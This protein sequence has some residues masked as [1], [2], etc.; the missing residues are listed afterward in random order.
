MVRLTSGW[1]GAV[2]ME[3]DKA[4]ACRF[5]A[6]FLSMDAPDSVDDLVRD[7]LGELANMIGG[8]LKCVLKGGMRLSLP[9]VIETDGDNLQ[10]GGRVDS[11]S[12]LSDGG[13]TFWRDHYQHQLR[14]SVTSL[15]RSATGPGSADRRRSAPRPCPRSSTAAIPASVT[16]PRLR[17]RPSVPARGSAAN[18]PA[19]TP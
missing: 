1:N 2:L 7:V 8:N 10:G 5:T 3:C 12:V 14:Q 18:P 13:R 17:E 15:V 19:S 16:A 4:Q 6:R 9:S 11:P